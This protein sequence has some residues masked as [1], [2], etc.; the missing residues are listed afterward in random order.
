MACCPGI[1]RTGP[2]RGD[3][4]DAAMSKREPTGL[5]H[6]PIDGKCLHLCIDMQGMFADDTPWHTPW[7]RQMRPAVERLVAAHPDRTIFT[8]FIP[9]ERAEDAHGAWR[10]YYER[11]SCMTGEQIDRS[12]IE[13]LPEL[14]AHV[15]P[16]TVV[17]KLHYSPFM[18]SDLEQILTSRDADT[19]IISGAETEVCVLATVL[20]A[21]DR[22][23]RVIVPI[24][25]VCSS[26]DE[27]HDALITV[28]HSRFGQQ[29]ETTRTDDLLRA[30]Q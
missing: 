21:I 27:T 19:L 13:L 26:A 20:D 11:W 7:M 2:L 3:D 23:Y 16:A 1:C 29:I 6:G 25:A 9:V 15:P 30:W 28:Y 14:R 10:R 4:K 12:W 18:T 24:D 17:D 5:I 8:R 22:G